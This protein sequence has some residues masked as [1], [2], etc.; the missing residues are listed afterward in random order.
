MT[1]K[2]NKRQ[3]HKHP[4]W[5]RWRYWRQAC[6]NLDSPNYAYV[7]ARG[8]GI[9]FSDFWHMADYVMRHLG[10]PP[11]GSSSRLARIDQSGNFAPGNLRWETGSELVGRNSRSIQIK[12]GRRRQC[13]SKWARDL[14]MDP[15][16]VY[17][18][19]RSY[20]WD[21]KR[22]LTTPVKKYR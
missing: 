20:G 8:I 9:D 19:V 6:Y 16:L 22:A 11:L 12:I 2:A 15:R 7:G 1:V 18:R 21:H 14:H 17:N 10:P 4:L 3:A 13:L 5:G